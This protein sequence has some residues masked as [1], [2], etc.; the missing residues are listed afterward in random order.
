MPTPTRAQWALEILRRLSH[1]FPEATTEL[2]YT[3]PFE[4]LMAVVLSAQ[5][6]DVRVNMVTPAL[7]ARYPDAFTLALATAEEV[8]PFIATV[9]LYHNK[10]RHLVGLAKQLVQEHGGMVPRE[11]E[12]LEALPGVGRKTANVVLA[13]VMGEPA[14]AVDTHVFRVANRLGLAESTDVRKT[15]DQLMEL[16]PRTRWGEAHH[17]LIFLGRRVCHARKPACEHCSL[18]ELCRTWRTLNGIPAD[19]YVTR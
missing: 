11:R 10:A 2:S 15:E 3:N 8:E 17:Q 7:F 16:L 12:A 14:I 1:Q 13:T 4:L 6:T 18:R 19:A 5:T 9:G